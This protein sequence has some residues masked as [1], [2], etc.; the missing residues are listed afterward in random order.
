MPKGVCIFIMTQVCILLRGV[1][2]ATG[3]YACPA[4]TNEIKI[5]LSISTFSSSTLSTTVK[6]VRAG[7]LL[8]PSA[9][10]I[11]VWK[12]SSF[13]RSDDVGGCGWEGALVSQSL[14]VVKNCR[15]QTDVQL[16]SQE[17][18]ESPWARA[19]KS[20]L[21]LVLIVTTVVVTPH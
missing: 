7:G 4:S 13:L 11:L 6:V 12:C 19:T 3:V 14:P 1:P 5:L 8:K 21:R 20:L 9:K 16:A 17:K 15:Y 10:C 2:E 18:K